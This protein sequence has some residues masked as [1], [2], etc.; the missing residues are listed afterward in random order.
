MFWIV[1]IVVLLWDK[2]LIKRNR[3][4]QCRSASHKT[5]HKTVVV[6]V[7]SWTFITLWN[8]KVYL[9]DKGFFFQ[10]NGFQT[11]REKDFR[12][13]FS[14]QN[15]QFSILITLQAKTRS[16]LAWAKHQVTRDQVPMT[17]CLAPLCQSTHHF[18]QQTSLDLFW[19]FQLLLLH[20]L[21]SRQ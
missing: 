8:K 9:Q 6:I 14:R 3:G 10:P 4:D 2:L 15:N 7:V 1:L 12:N 20:W 18:P 16:L 13:T 11:N 19:V 17:P 21:C 5:S